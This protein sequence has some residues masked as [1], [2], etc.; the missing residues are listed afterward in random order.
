VARLADEP[1]SRK[2]NVPSNIVTK[3]LPMPA[4]ESFRQARMHRRGAF[5]ANA[6]SAVLGKHANKKPGA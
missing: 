3:W 1:A 4:D 2:Q 5:T 6:H